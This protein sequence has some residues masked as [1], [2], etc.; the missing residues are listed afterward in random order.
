MPFMGSFARGL[1]TGTQNVVSRVLY[2]NTPNFS[3]LHKL[4]LLLWGYKIS[5]SMSMLVWRWIVKKS[6][7]Q[8]CVGPG[9]IVGQ[10]FVTIWFQCRE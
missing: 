5:K 10:Y 6:K 9:T 8:V 3:N 2:T 7:Q 4:L 1:Y